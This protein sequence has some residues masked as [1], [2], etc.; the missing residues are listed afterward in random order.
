MAAER[1]IELDTVYSHYVISQYRQCGLA[2][3]DYL[4]L[5]WRSQ[6]WRVL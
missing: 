3:G 4:E 5:I 2:F 6:G 1:L